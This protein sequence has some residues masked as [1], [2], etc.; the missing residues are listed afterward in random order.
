MRFSGPLFGPDAPNTGGGPESSPRRAGSVSLRESLAPGGNDSDSPLDPANQSMADALRIVLRLLQFG[1]VVLAAMYLF[2]GFKFVNEGQ[3]GIRLLFGAR[4]GPALDPGLQ[5]NAPFPLGELVLIDRGL[6]DISIDKDFWVYMQDGTPDTVTIDKI[7]PSESLKPDQGGSGSVLTAD[8]NIAHTRWSV[9]YRREDAAKYAQHVLDANETEL[10]RAAVKRGVVQACAHVTVDEL[11]KQ[12]ADQTASVASRAKAV[13]QRTLDNMECG[14]VIDQ[15]TLRQAVPPLWV[16]SDF[17]RVQSAVANAAKAVE[18]ARSDANNA[19]NMAAGEAAPYLVKLIESY[20]DAAAKKNE[21]AM[22]AILARID[23]VM[24]GEEVEIDGQKISGL[25]GGN[26]T[27]KL[28]DAGQYRS[29]IVT[30]A[31]GRMDRHTAK[32]AQFKANPSLMVHHEWTD[33]LRAFIDRPTVQVMLAPK[34]IGT[35]RMQISPDP[36]IL[37]DIDRAMKKKESEQ[38]E[39]DRME[40]LKQNR[41]KTDVNTIKVRG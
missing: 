17:A 23:A 18:Q 14:I 30:K 24:L 35:L 40:M 29:A 1:M 25:A 28:A 8:G 19:L 26:V 32:L 16:R 38:T 36:S 31:K 12:S 22:T 27:E 41:F 34:E 11:L 5:V 33:A 39:A 4:Q 37:R 13:A 6:K 15:L 7:S 3:Q 10:V 2:S 20:E 21:P 9:G